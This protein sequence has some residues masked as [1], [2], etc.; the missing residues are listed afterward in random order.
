MASGCP[1][2]TSDVTSMPETAGDAALLA[3]PDDRDGLADAIIKACG[4]EGERLRSA[5]FER[6][7]EFTWARTAERTLAV[8]RDVYARRAK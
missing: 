8:Y 7:R 5:G 4:P 3:S 6:A 2:V 1:V